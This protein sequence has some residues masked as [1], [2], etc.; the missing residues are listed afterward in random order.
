MRAT[1]RLRLAKPYGVPADQPTP[2]PAQALGVHVPRLQQ[3]EDAIFGDFNP[4]PPFGIAWWAPGPG[5]TRRILIG[6]HLF[7]CAMGTRDNLIE[8]G[9]HWTEFIDYAEQEDDYFVDA[10][11]IEGG[12]VVVRA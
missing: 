11:Q 8:A 1:D 5:T 10:V 7:A 12:Q 3:L 4:G 9:L 6:D 2:G